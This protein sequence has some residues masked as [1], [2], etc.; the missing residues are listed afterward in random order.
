[1]KKKR[2]FGY[3]ITFDEVVFDAVSGD[4]TVKEKPVDD[5][6]FRLIAL[7]GFILILVAI[8]RVFFLGVLQHDF[9]RA[10]ASANI[11]KVLLKLAPRGLILDRFGQPLTENKPILTLYLRP[12]ELVRNNEL[13]RVIALFE[14]IG[15]NRDELYG[16][17]NR[18][19]LQAVDTI[20]IKKGLSIDEAI[21]VRGAGLLS[22]TVENDF[23]R[24]FEPAFAHLVGYT[25]LTTKED[26]LKRNLTSIDIVG[27]SGLE[28]YYDDILRGE[29]G[30]TVIYRNSAGEKI[31]ERLLSEPRIG[32]NVTTTIDA[33]FQQYFYDRLI[34]GLKSLGRSKAVGIALNPLNGEVL[35][36]ISLPSFGADQNQIIKAL[37]D[38][39][40][41]FF[42]RAV[43]GLYSPGSTIKPLLAA[44][45]L[46][47]RLIQPTDKILSVGY[48]EI[49]NPYFPDRPTRFLDW[50]PH[51]WVDLYSAIARSSNVYFY[52]VGGGWQRQRGLG[53]NKIIEYFHFFGLDEKTG[54]DLPGESRGFILSPAEKE[55]RTGQIWRIGDTYNISIGQGDMAVTP[56]S[57]LSAIASVINGGRLYKPKLLLDEPPKIIKEY[58]ELQPHFKEVVSGMVDAVRQPYGTSHL[59]SD[60]PIKIAA[61][62]GSAQIADNT[63]T[64]AFWVGCGPIP[65][66][67]AK[68]P[69]CVLVLIEDAKEG[70]LNA[71]PIA[72]DVMKWYYENRLR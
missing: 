50:K 55:K 6:I 69:I 10:R 54:I 24:L 66:E 25:G 52:A 11:N 13:D 22:V 16:I 48:I 29:N 39:D 57:L 32:K 60:L 51:G 47:E 8:G 35:S 18:S 63:K 5:R 58:T 23:N 14:S 19:D 71:V 65:I 27:K 20:I 44:A 36:L 21:K 38:P 2:R 30:K 7:V 59:L 4:L 9:Y 42:N 15:I 33:E 67:E 40:Q 53:I 70:S 28:Y 43:A 3:E 12:A 62:T 56:I 72:Y 61:K 41:P 17:L 64:N 34:R 26:I 45:A 68:T 31:E 49:P 37:G 1:M 46:N